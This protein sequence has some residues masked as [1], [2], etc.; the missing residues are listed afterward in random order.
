VPLD[1]N[2]RLIGAS[3][4]RVEDR[5]LT[6]GAA[7]YLDDLEAPG[8][9][10]LTLARSVHAHA[11]LVSIDSGR[12][13][14]EFPDAVVVTGRDCPG[15]GIRADI[16]KPGAQHTF[17]PCLAVD[18]VRFVGEPVAAVLTGDPYRSEDAAELLDVQYEVLEPVLGIERALAPDAPRLHPG[19]RDNVFVRRLRGGGDLEAAARE[20]DLVVRRRFRTN[21][22]PACSWRTAAAWPCST[23]RGPS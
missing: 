3:V 23:P 22:T 19:W 20:A 1:L 5:R 18:L 14:E 6:T 10:H 21:R 12:L 11:R 2:P 17:Q 13:R 4:R 7:R 15:L 9:L 16:D 8:A